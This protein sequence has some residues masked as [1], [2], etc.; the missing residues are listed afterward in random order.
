MSQNKYLVPVEGL[1]VRHPQGGHLDPA[2]AHVVVNGYWRK[3]ISEGSVTVGEPPVEP[4]AEEPAK[5]VEPDETQLDAPAGNKPNT[6][7]KE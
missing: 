6:K 7:G 2:G 5:V 4:V 3:R 1:K